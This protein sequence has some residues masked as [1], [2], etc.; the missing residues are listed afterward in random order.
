VT[1][2]RFFFCLNRSTRGLAAFL[3]VCAAV[4]LSAV[5]HVIIVGTYLDLEP[6]TIGSAAAI[7]ATVGLIAIARRCHGWSAPG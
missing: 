4:M 1:R 3:S 7:A 5:A 6:L 2:Y